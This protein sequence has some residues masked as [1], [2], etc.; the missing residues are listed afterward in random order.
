MVIKTI[1]FKI[2]TKNRKWGSF[3]IVTRGVHTSMKSKENKQNSKG[4]NTIQG[5][6]SYIF[7]FRCDTDTICGKSITVIFSSSSIYRKQS[8]IV[9]QRRKPQKKSCN[10]KNVVL[11]LFN[12]NADKSSQVIQ[13]Y[14]DVKF[15]EITMNETMFCQPNNYTNNCLKNCLWVL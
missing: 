15:I 13:A 11:Y 5:R 10:E 14:H 4:H 12:D 7:A 2:Q 3:Q 9:N 8:Q 6:G 1:Y